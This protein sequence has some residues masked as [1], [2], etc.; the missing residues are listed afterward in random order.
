MRILT[1]AAVGLAVGL[2]LLGSA[3]EAGRMAQRVPIEL[4]AEEQQTLL[5]L[6]RERL[7]AHVRGDRE[8]ELDVTTLSAALQEEAA[9]FVTLNKDGRLR[10]CILDRF[11]AHESI[12]ENVRRNVVL[13][14]TGDPRFAP[15]RLEELANLS[16]E[17]SILGSPYRLEFGSAEDLIAALHPGEHGV[18]LTTPYGTSTYLPQVWEQ[19]PNPEE[20]L[21]S[22]CLKH[23]APEGCWREAPYPRVELYRVFHFSEDD[24]PADAD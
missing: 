19:I 23:G 6:A 8:S 10:G 3:W 24:I 18:I 2:L 5:R 17:I 15:V 16:I 11:D 14:A 22:L 4:T 20:F 13:A 21:S 1:I 12:A 7:S 9:C